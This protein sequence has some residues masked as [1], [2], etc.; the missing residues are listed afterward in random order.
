MNSLKSEYKTVLTDGGSSYTEKKSEFIGTVKPVKTEQEALEFLNQIKK[1]YADA[2]HNVYAYVVQKD[3]I[4]RYSD[5]GEPSGTGGMPVL[6][7][8][9][10]SGLTDV[11]VVVTRYFGGTLLGTGGLVRAYSK[12]AADAVADANP[13]ICRLCKCYD[14]VCDYTLSGKIAHI[15]ENDDYTLENTEYTD[16]VKFSACVKQGCDGK[17]IKE[18]T[19]ATGAKAQI[20]ETESK[21][22]NIPIKEAN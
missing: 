12:A 16:S 13:V 20:T 8:I 22:I 11:A 4:Q 18:I 6:G 21:Y 10:K 3:N 9:T 14:I 1:K 2:R 17:F 7:V 15:L 5:D 19:E